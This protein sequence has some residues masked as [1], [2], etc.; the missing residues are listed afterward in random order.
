MVVTRKAT[1]DVS[2]RCR[3]VETRP[4]REREGS[5]SRARTVFLEK[6]S[7]V[8]SGPKKETKGK[9]AFDILFCTP[10]NEVAEVFTIGEQKY[11]SGASGDFNW[12]KATGLEPVERRRYVEKLLGAALRHIDA[13]FNAWPDSTRA[14]IDEESG[15]PHLAHAC[16]NLLMALDIL[17]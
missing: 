1:Q 13:E 15:K 11:P 4:S 16:A 8:S 10:I 12:R 9:P 6:G 7:F 14:T 5:T 2:C 17:S 3:K